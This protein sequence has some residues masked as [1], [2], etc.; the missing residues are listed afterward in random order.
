MKN[1]LLIAALFASVF[2][3]GQVPI[4]T[5][6][7]YSGSRVGAYAPI[8]V[9]GLNRRVDM[10]TLPLYTDTIILTKTAGQTAIRPQNNHFYISDGTKWNDASTGSSSGQATWGTLVGTLSSQTDLQTALNL[11]LNKTDTA[12]F[13]RS[14]TE[15]DPSYTANGVPKTRTITINGTALDLSQNRS[16]TIATNAG[17]VAWG[18]VTG[19]L[20][21]QNDLQSALNS[22]LNISDT[23]GR[24]QT[25]GSYLLNEVDPTVPSYVK[26]ISTTNISNWNTSYSWGN[27]S[28]AGYMHLAGADTITG[29][30]TFMQP[31]II[32][33]ATASN[34]A[35][36]LVQVKSQSYN[37]VTNLANEGGNIA[38]D[39]SIS[40]I[41]SYLAQSNA[42]LIVN[43]PVANSDIQIT[44]IQDGT[45]SRTVTWPSSFKWQGGTPPTLS[46]APG[47][48]DII[49]CT[50]NGTDHY[51]NIGKD[52]R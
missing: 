2:N 46:T 22:K 43:N 19:T 3:Y 32:P 40:R 35:V 33:L 39:V 30:K 21:S 24:W 17:S 4:S 49:T 41:A 13:L 16:W 15:S 5:M 12:G 6:P 11:K 44:I 38:W 23:V 48:K 51:C 28:L 10:S 37:T 27:H 29:N 18:A 45:G 50:Y 52:Y 20:S 42:T 26:S 36:S 47:A 1:L 25:K 31:I 7:L 34:H 9:N 8:V 14:Y